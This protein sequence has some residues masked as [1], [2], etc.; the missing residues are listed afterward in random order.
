MMSKVGKVMKKVFLDKVG[1]PKCEKSGLFF[2]KSG[3]ALGLGLE[4]G[5]AFQGVKIFT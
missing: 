5:M 4:C 3:L 1:A 2:Q